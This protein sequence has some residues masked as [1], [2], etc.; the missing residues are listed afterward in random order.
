MNDLENKTKTE[1]LRLAR[2]YLQTVGYNGFSFQHLADDLG[3]KKASLHYY[4]KSKDDLGLALVEYYQAGFERWA[5]Q[6][7]ELTP[8]KKLQA[9]VEVFSR[10]AEDDFKVCPMGALSIDLKVL[11][12]KLKHKVLEFHNMQRDWLVETLKQGK[13]TK[14]FSSHI[15]PE[16]VA[17]IWM[18]STQGGLIISRLRSDSQCLKSILKGVQ[19]LIGAL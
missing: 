1:A 19:K 10:F 5:M 3:I 17:D 14:E 12:K 8:K 9:V 13:K 7:A 6:V 18:A 4:F 2:S 11:S 16:A 15:D